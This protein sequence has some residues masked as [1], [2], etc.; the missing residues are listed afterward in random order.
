MLLYEDSTQQLCRFAYLPHLQKTFFSGPKVDRPSPISVE[1]ISS[2][3]EQLK[4]VAKSAFNESDYARNMETQVSE[5]VMDNN[6]GYG[7]PFEKLIQMIKQGTAEH[8]A[9]KRKHPSIHAKWT[10][11]LYHLAQVNVNPSHLPFSYVA[12]S[13]LSCLMCFKAFE[14]FSNAEDELAIAS[15][16]RLRLCLK[17]C[18][19]KIY[20]PWIAVATKNLSPSS[21]VVRHELW[22]SLVHLYSQFLFQQ[23]HCIR[24]LSDSTNNSANSQDLGDIKN[25]GVS[26]FLLL[27]FVPFFLFSIKYGRSLR[28]TIMWC[29]NTFVI[30][31]L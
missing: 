19:G 12:V 11:V 30:C 9:Q 16:K 26:T 20:Y 25:T 21:T 22:Q 3:A 24:I 17:G 5:S 1:R 13:K 7:D 6:E 18:N 4:A 23:K 10:L 2:A 27:I 15:N 28:I 8:G 14:G 31:Y 29:V